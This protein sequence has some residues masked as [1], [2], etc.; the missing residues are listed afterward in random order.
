M[1]ARHKIGWKTTAGAAVGVTALLA[2]IPAFAP[3]DGPLRA[4]SAAADQRLTPFQDCE[5]LT[6]WYVE[7]ALP[8]VTAWG[9]DG[10][11][12]V[13][14]VSMSDGVV[15][16]AVPEATS[17]GFDAVGNGPTGTNVQ[18][19]G[20]DEPDV[21]KLYGENL[22][23]ST[24]GNRL[25]LTDVSGDTPRV[26]SERVLSTRGWSHELLIV[27][28]T[29]IVFG[30]RQTY[31]PHDVI[32][33]GRSWPSGGGASV[34]LVTTLD[35]SDPAHP[36]PTSREK[37]SGS[38][39]TA[40]EHDGTVRVV[41]SS[42]PNLDFVNPWDRP[43]HRLWDHKYTY[44]EAKARNREIVRESSAADWLPHRG[45]DN[46]GEGGEPLLSCD[47]VAHP[48]KGAGLGT[49]TV[50]TLDPESPRTPDAIG[51]SAE[52]SLVY[53]STD[54]LYVSTIKGGWTLWSTAA[55]PGD[56]RHP[57]TE[58]HAFATQGTETAYF[59]SGSVPGVAP[60]RW[61]FSEYDG[62]LRVATRRDG[63]DQPN[64]SAV[65]VLEERGSR[66]VAVGGVG[67]L[68]KSEEIQAVRWF[69]DVAVVVTFRQTDPL[70][71]LDLSN[72]SDPRVTGELKITGFSEYLHPLGD[73]L[74]LGVGQSATTTGT[75]TGGQV[76][77]FD[78]SDLSSPGL[79]DRLPLGDRHSWSPVAQD[80]RAF[81]YLPEQR[82]AFVPFESW[83]RGGTGIA[84][85]S[86]SA[87]G[88]LT[89]TQPI[90]VS[91]STYGLRALPLDEDR[92]AV[93]SA[94]QVQ[95]VVNAG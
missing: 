49:I 67:G 28:D 18:E 27:G 13:W 94:G 19:A 53:A 76:S 8:E 72:P 84:V 6:D 14:D 2:A 1:V 81:T 57:E 51:V 82:L 71:T 63:P 40:R 35:L 47:A 21:A 52:G 34:S 12:P 11:G 69:G 39:A 74:L 80:A 3:S 9:L 83:G 70:Y 7:Q 26:V 48:D 30:T 77:T 23:V 38:I 58:V 64:D 55:D 42:S 33:T 62:M 60:D 73:D 41:L 46:R 85:I 68:G 24:K 90:Q 32:V 92:I 22:V 61:A 93:V 31:Y 54:R 37:Y 10:G 89:S 20:V 87:N 78:L 86:V 59:A 36:E 15:R 95:S 5:R 44:R 45:V 50:V 43:W 79:L 25:V 88:G 91:R 56:W 65:T 75:T 4:Q 16:T 66:L 29:A 17:S